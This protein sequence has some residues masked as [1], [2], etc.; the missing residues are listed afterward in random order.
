MEPWLYPAYSGKVLLDLELG[1]PFGDA[2]HRPTGIG[3]SFLACAF[4]LVVGGENVLGTYPDVNRF[5][6][7]TVGNQYGQFSPFG[8]N[9][10][11]QTRG[12]RRCGAKTT[13]EN[14]YYY[15]RLNYRW[16]GM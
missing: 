15:T 3:K 13:R 14:A 4:T 9:G 11:R 5:G 8:F 1:I 2:H 7:D 6:T 12:T 16:G 10:A